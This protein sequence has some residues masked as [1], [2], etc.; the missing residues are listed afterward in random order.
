MSG[1]NR[2]FQVFES[3]GQDR[4]VASD[5]VRDLLNSAGQVRF[6]SPHEIHTFLTRNYQFAFRGAT[7]QF[8]L[9]GSWHAFYM[10]GCLLT[11]VKT[12]ETFMRR[13]PHLTISAAAGL[14]WDDEIMKLT[15]SGEFVPKAGGMPQASRNGDF[16]A[17][18]R[19]GGSTAEI[20]ASDDRW[21]N[22]CH[23]DF[24][25]EFNGAGALELYVEAS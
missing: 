22:S 13:R 6:A 20:I 17:L 8:V 12:G 10:R 4:S 23:F 7:D 9:P 18:Q 11:R 21:A 1:Y 14:G 16:R 3:L 15:R 19:L 2:A 5:L 24:V 25:P